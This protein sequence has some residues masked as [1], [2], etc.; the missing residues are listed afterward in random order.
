MC[1]VSASSGAPRPLQEG[2]YLPGQPP[3]EP[4][5]D[6]GF[7]Q[8]PADTPQSTQGGPDIPP[9]ALTAS[10]LQGESTAA[11]CKPPPCLSRPSCEGG[12]VQGPALLGRWVS[13]VRLDPQDPAGLQRAVPVSSAPREHCGLGLGGGAGG[14]VSIGINERERVSPGN[15]DCE[16]AQIKHVSRRAP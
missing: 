7:A 15:A 8:H 2:V 12:G 9:P 16:P 3:S 14:S 4:R 13:G 6:A 11:P 1:C 10:C 5:G